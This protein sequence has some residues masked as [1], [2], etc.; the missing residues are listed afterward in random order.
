MQVQSQ[1]LLRIV[2]VVSLGGLGAALASQYVLGMQPCPWCILQRLICMLLAIVCAAGLGSDAAIVHRIAGVPAALLALCGMA[3]AIWQHFEAAKSD[4]CVLT[5]ADRIVSEYSHLDRWLP[6]V[7][8]VRATCA[9]AEAAL[10][11]IPYEFWS[12][13]LFA[14]LFLVAARLVVAPRGASTIP[15]VA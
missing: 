5:L 14:I 10:L 7:F 15:S 9:Q 1:T 3:S 2:L 4:A 8:A 13:G 6:S 12:L 11:G